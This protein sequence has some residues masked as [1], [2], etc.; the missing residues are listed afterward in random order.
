MELIMPVVLASGLD[1]ELVDPKAMG[2]FAPSVR[3][4]LFA[5]GCRSCADGTIGQQI[6]D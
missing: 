6:S 5:R 3:T 4:R 2:G 1:P